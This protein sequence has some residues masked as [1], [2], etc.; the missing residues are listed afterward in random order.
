MASLKQHNSVVTILSLASILLTACGTTQPSRYYLLR[1]IPQT[2]IE[3]PVIQDKAKVHIGVG[4][5]TVPKYLDRSPIVK[6]SAGTEVIIDDM[7]RWAEPLADNISRVVANNLYL[8]INAAD[9]SIHPWQIPHIIDYQVVV[10]VLRFDADTNNTIVL[11][12]HWTINGKA[13]KHT[14]FTKKTIINA[15]ASN[16]D[17]ATLVSTQSRATEILSREIADKLAEIIAQGN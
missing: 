13:D 2:T 8:L 10:D 7:H 14:L 16:S 4:P 17:Y 12:A 11:T 15:Q 6:R 1:S 9:V 3:K 5:I